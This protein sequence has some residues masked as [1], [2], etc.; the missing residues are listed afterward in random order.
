LINNLAPTYDPQRRLQVYIPSLAAYDFSTDY[1]RSVPPSMFILAHHLLA[2]SRTNA[3]PK[4]IL[5]TFYATTIL[6]IGNATYTPSNFLGGYFDR[7]QTSY[8][9]LKLA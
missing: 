5:R 1:G 8:Q 6:E 3:E 4:T 9:P 2:S 7:M